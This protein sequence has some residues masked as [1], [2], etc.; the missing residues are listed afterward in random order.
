MSS[1]ISSLLS[2]SGSTTFLGLGFSAAALALGLA[3]TLSLGLVSVALDLD[4]VAVVVPVAF[5]VLVL[6]VVFLAGFLSLA[7]GEDDHVEAVKLRMGSAVAT[8]DW[9]QSNWAEGATRRTAT[10]PTEVSI[11]RGGFGLTGGN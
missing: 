1:L 9:R 10:L 7:V 11:V 8:A 2:F 4:L 5:L 3:L 6:V